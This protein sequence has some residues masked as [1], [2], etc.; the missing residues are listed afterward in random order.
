MP[1]LNCLH[2]LAASMIGIAARTSMGRLATL[3]ELVATQ[4]SP[5][6]WDGCPTD[7]RPTITHMPV[8][9][10]PLATTFGSIDGPPCND[11]P[12]KQINTN[13]VETQITSR[14]SNRRFVFQFFSPP[15]CSYGQLLSEQGELRRMGEASGN[16][17][18]PSTSP[19]ARR[20]SRRCGGHRLVMARCR[21]M[22]QR[23]RLKA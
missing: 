23:G 14:Y 11:R 22:R 21:L 10:T 8:A 12:T 5:A 7:E 4:I 9:S 1:R 6:R 18:G 19:P 2:H 3:S 20:R 15:S 13:R 16:A 17:G